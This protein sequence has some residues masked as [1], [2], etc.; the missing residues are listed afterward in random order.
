MK[1]D[2]GLVIYYKRENRYSFNALLGALEI[3]E[4]YKDIAIYIFEKSD[5]LINGLKEIVEKHKF[6]ILS[7]SFFTPQLWSIK[8]LVM[9]IR[10]RFNRK[11]IMIAGGPHP[12]GDPLFPLKIGFNYVVMG[13]GEEPFI[14]IIKRLLE[15][16]D[17]KD[18]KGIAFLDE[19][20]NLRYNKKGE[21]LDLNK[22]PPFS[23]KNNKFGPIEITRGCPYVCY[24]CQTPYIFGTKIRHRSIEK[25]CEYIEIMKERALTDIRF[26]T[27]NAF[28][29][30]SSDGKN[31][32]IKRLVELLENI[33][34][35]IKSKGRIF[36]GSFPSEVRPEHISEETVKLIKEYANNDNLVIGAQSGSPR[37]LELSHRGHTVEDVYN[38]VELTIKAGLKAYVDFIFGLPHETEEDIKLT[39]KMMEDLIKMGAKI[40]AHTFIPLPQTP[41]SK[42]PAGKINNELV[43]V[44]NKLIPKSLVFGNWEEQEKIAKKIEKYLKNFPELDL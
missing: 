33:R 12:T 26:I 18:L 15:G 27:P 30:G 11:I 32:N 3:Q 24:F 22:Y 37:I 25:I 10:K 20:N 17:L 43:K 19:E 34:R 44:L 7:V 40:H 16:K 14:E 8:S 35:I 2:L 31:L 38:A 29:Y 36:F 21:Y 28:S 1:K 4:F 42:M 39:I 23:I 6:V 5:N 13:E 41:F 9:K